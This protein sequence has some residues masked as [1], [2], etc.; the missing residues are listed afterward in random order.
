MK[1][2]VLHR[3]AIL[4]LKG[5][6]THAFHAKMTPE[7]LYG[8]V[9]DQINTASFGF[10]NF[11][12]L[13][14]DGIISTV[15]SPMNVIACL[16]SGNVYRKTLLPTYKAHRDVAKEKR[17]PLEDEQVNLCLELV[18]NFLLSQGIPL[19][20][21]ENEEADDVIA[22]L[23]EN[24]EGPK[25]VYTVDQDLISLNGKAIIMY[26]NIHTDNMK[27]VPA[28]C[29]TLHKSILGDKSDGYIGVKGLGDKAWD[30]MVEEFGYD[31]ME[32]IDELMRTSNLRQLKA[33]TMLTDNKPFRKCVEAY[34]DWALM[35]RVAKLHP[36][37][38]TNPKKPLEWRKRAPTLGRLVQVMNQAKCPDLIEKYSRDVYNTILVTQ[39]N[40]LECLQTIEK[41]TEETPFVAWD[42]ETYDPVKNP[43]YIKAANGRTYVDMIA[44]KITGCSFSF[45]RNANRVFYFSVFHK[46]TN[47]V[48]KYVILNI[49]K[50]LESKRVMVAQNCMPGDTEVLTKSGWRFI[51]T[52]DVTEDIMQWWPETGTLE[53]VKPLH[54]TEGFSE[55]LLEWGKGYHKGAYT[56]EHRVYYKTRKDPVW[57]VKPAI[58]V[59]KLHG[60][61][62]ILPL[63]GIYASDTQL[64]LSPLETR[65][66]EAI[67]A[68]GSWAERGSYCRFHFS[69]ARKT[70]RLVTLLD[71]LGLEYSM[72]QGTVGD[73]TIGVFANDISTKILGLLGRTKIYGLWLL[74]LPTA[75]KQTL[76]G[77]LHHWDGHSGKNGSNS[78]CS[79]SVETVEALQ[80]LA[81]TS[82]WRLKG[83]FKPNSKSHWKP[84]FVGTIRHSDHC[85]LNAYNQKAQVIE[86]NDKVYCFTV[87][88]GAFMIRRNGVVAI[89]G[90]CAFEATITLNQFQ[91]EISSWE[92]TKLYAHH[93]DENSENGLK[94]LSLSY[95]NYKQASYAETLAAAGAA[96]MSEISGED[97]LS[98]GCDDSLV[99]AHLYSFFVIQTMLE[100]T[101]DFIR[102]YEC[103]AVAPLVYAHL[104]GV[105][106]DKL[107]LEK[108]KA[109]DEVT[110][111]IKMAA[112]REQLEEHCSEPNP[113][114][115][116][117]LFEDQ[118]DYIAYKAKVGL[119]K[120]NPNSSP[121]DIQ[122]AVKAALSEYKT[123]LK[124]NCY[125]RPLEQTLKYKPFVPT[126]TMF[127]TVFKM[128]GLPEVEKVN[129]TSL[130]DWITDNPC[131]LGKLIAPAIPF[132]DAKKRSGKEYEALENYCNGILEQGGT[133]VTS[134]TELNMGS[135]VQNTYLFYLLLDLPIRTR[136][137]V[138]KGSTRHKGGFEGS[139]STDETAVQ[140]ALANDCE[141]KPW[142][143]QLLKDL[144]DYKDAA[145]RMGLFWT[146]YPLW[147]DDEDRMHPGFNSCG[148]IT[149]R[150]TGGN[151][152]LLQVS[153]GPVRQVFVPDD[154][155]HVIASIDFS[156]QELRVLASKCQDPT[157]L[158]AYPTEGKS[159]DLHALTAC[160]LAPLFITREEGISLLDLVMDSPTRV[161]YE[162][163]KANYEG[164]EK[165]G[166]FLSQCRYY[167]KTANFGVAYSAG[168]LTMALQLMITLE[169]GEIIVEAMN[170]TY[171]G[172]AAWKSELYKQA[173]IDG[174]VATTYGSRRHCGEG[175]SK[176][177]RSEM[178]RW[179]RQLSNFAIQGQCADLLKVALVTMHDNGT[180]RKY[181][182]R[183]I[184]PIYD[185]LLFHVPKK[186]LQ[187]FLTAA[188]DDMEQPMPGITIPM[189]ADCSFGANWG[190]QVEVGNRPSL[191]KVNAALAKIEAAKAELKLAA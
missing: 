59:D 133:L 180:L 176:G 61:D 66:M 7:P 174:Y 71:D 134:G 85:K 187:P 62:V 3:W 68:D 101:W 111:E 129:K 74:D 1:P 51:S 25:V 132:F 164:G 102:R 109:A 67:R 172:I 157:F 120:K 169:E 110:I 38:C 126:V 170:N 43:N 107:E 5:I 86:H 162:W 142:K 184:A 118:A 93:V 16:D 24:L 28:T 137:K 159:L 127:N 10:T 48:D 156:S 96:D 55:T 124:E 49:I 84:L 91:H 83:D 73:T 175:L 149:R 185:E 112:I 87:P 45:G 9:K 148:T 98:Y 117:T 160:G 42:Y 65:F 56:P 52:V 36:E 70:E 35:Y 80:I 92:D 100:K 2:S 81:H 79:T 72:T 30:T 26:R 69:K 32:E 29:I 144:L 40:L 153:K 186:T 90:N 152:N 106:L 123:K 64:D 54:K 147:A 94:S 161:N 119:T 20:K 11:L 89:T 21:L 4:D 114:A 15:E 39:D 22:Y 135:P 8:T 188:C 136:T 154:D 151:P 158:S 60:N 168:P 57:R 78:F 44:S 50:F 75:S 130:S 115:V 139:P 31:G 34:Q 179:E 19:V 125:Y 171:P 104:G 76:L 183:L 53:F 182:A 103:P 95:L 145:T 165:L 99:T 27:G 18:K 14:Y 17:D 82:G 131:E 163:F 178:S 141:G 166:K 138:Q 63:S 47:N 155:D 191:E 167:A 177:S 97:V 122:N 108:Q 37:L 143:R 113:I 23:V 105:K 146:P 41:L 46:D 150:P 121:E 181:G 128:L 33:T 6:V 140:Y 173:R 12:N 13:Y 77:E 189:V 190:Q 58:E 116:Q 88:S